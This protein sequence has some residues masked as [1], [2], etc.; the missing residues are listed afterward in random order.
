M[1][2]P[3]QESNYTSAY[4]LFQTAFDTTE[5]PTFTQIWSRR[6]RLLSL[7]YWVNGKLIGVSIVCGHRLHYIYIDERY[8][9]KGFGSEL[10]QT[11]LAHSP[12]LHLTPVDNPK[13]HAWYV[14]HGFRLSQIHG[15]YRLYAHHD[16]DLRSIH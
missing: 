7:G 9:S 12:T 8:R 14:Q 16:H 6:S 13:I 11:I 5:H 15:A 10:L 2:V 3:L 1:I 4:R